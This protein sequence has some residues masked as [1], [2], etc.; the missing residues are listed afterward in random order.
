MYNLL[1]ENFLMNNGKLKRFVLAV[2][3][4]RK[5]GMFPMPG[6]EG[7]FAQ[8]EAA[9]HLCVGSPCHTTP[10]WQSACIG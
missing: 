10:G 9:L 5:Q 8:S 3:S 2:F 4:S 6:R 7:I 1:P